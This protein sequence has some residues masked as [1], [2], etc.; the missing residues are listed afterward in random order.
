MLLQQHRTRIRSLKSQWMN[1]MASSIRFDSHLHMAIHIATRVATMTGLQPSSLTGNPL[2]W[3]E[4][5]TT[6]HQHHAICND[7]D[8]EAE[9][10]STELHLSESD[11]SIGDIATLL[12]D[13]VVEDTE[14][15]PTFQP[16]SPATSPP[17][18]A[19]AIHLRWE[20]PVCGS[21]FIIF[22]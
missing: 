15:G 22:E 10:A 7:L 5:Y 21:S 17:P 19:P 14:D 8:D 9:N 3:L 13:F 1:P 12:G 11:D 18:S 6:E 20:L 16:P 2:T 4:L